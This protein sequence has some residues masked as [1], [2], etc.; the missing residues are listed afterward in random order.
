MS[1]AKRR[2]EQIA[3]RSKQAQRRKQGSGAATLPKPGPFIWGGIAL[4]ALGTVALIIAAF[5]G[6]R[7][8]A[9]TTGDASKLLNNAIALPGVLFLLGGVLLFL[10]I[11][12]RRAAWQ[13]HLERGFFEGGSVSFEL[14]PVP[15]T[16][17]LV[18]LIVPV[19]VWSLI[20]LAPVLGALADDGPAAWVADASDDFW[21]LSA[22]YGFV[23][24]GSLGVMLASLLKKL[25]YALFAPDRSPRQHATPDRPAS[26][27]RFWRLVSAQ[28]RAESWLGFAGLG[29]AGALPLLW[30]D[31]DASG[32]PLDDTAVLVFALVAVLST[33]AAAIV[34][35]NSWRSGAE[36]G[37][38]ESV[39]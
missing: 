7:G 30:R 26:A 12:F 39:A 2:R 6:L 32:Q 23:A 37:Y 31:A 3:A 29:F 25:G 27:Q 4:L 1:E 36:L 21:V 22:F 15:L 19:G 38:A 13:L 8:D 20:V 18:G 34:A 35:L 24:A 10:G 5:A 11:M 28:F 33:V 9:L 17:H 16:V 14:R